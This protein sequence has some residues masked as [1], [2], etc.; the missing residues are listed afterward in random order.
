VNTSADPADPAT[1]TAE[2]ATLSYDADGDGN[3][4]TDVAGFA[5]FFGLNDVYTNGDRTDF[6][7]DSGIR[8]ENWR[9]FVAGGDLRFSYRDDGGAMAAETV[10][11]TGTETLEDIAELI[12]DLNSDYLEAEIVPEGEGVRLRIKQEKATDLMITQDG[13]ATDLIDALGLKVSEAGVSNTIAVKKEI[14][15]NPSLIS[16]GAMIYNADTGEYTL[17]AGDNSTANALAEAMS[18]NIG[19]T[20]AGGLTSTTVTLT[21]Y[22]GLTLSLNSRQASDVETRLDYQ[23]SLVDTLSMK[24]AEISAVNLDEEMAQLI[25]FEQSYSASAKVIATVSDMFDVLNS[26]V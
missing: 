15:D 16:R 7:W 5:A 21:D 22:A 14:S 17:S 2:D 20:S 10:T 9:P 19:F 13:A 25:I 26:I 6:A 12:N 3:V 1:W 18:D 23:V 11:L 24:N 4:D 8:S